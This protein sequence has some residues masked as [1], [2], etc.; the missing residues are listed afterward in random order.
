MGP[1]GL[2]EPEEMEEPMRMVVR[3]RNRACRG[4]GRWIG[5][6]GMDVGVEGAVGEIGG[7][8]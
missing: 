7:G 5:A 2:E 8:M 3:G 4:R 1:A 6:W